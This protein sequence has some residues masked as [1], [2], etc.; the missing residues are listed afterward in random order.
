M[1]RQPSD[2]K[3][4]KLAEKYLCKGIWEDTLLNWIKG[5][6]EMLKDYGEGFCD[7]KAEKS[8]LKQSASSNTLD[9]MMN[10]GI[11]RKVFQLV[12]DSMILIPLCPV[13]VLSLGT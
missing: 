2:P 3:G 10:K 5:T 13:T 4:V 12:T 9:T 6:E 8:Q 1:H 7:F 11:F